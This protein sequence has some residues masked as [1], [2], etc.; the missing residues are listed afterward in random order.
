MRRRD[1]SRWLE[2]VFRDGPLASRISVLEDQAQTEDV[3]DV[4]AS[5]AQAI[6]ARYDTAPAIAAS[7]AP[8]VPA[9]RQN[10]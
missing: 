1:F 6:R 2:T 3:A 7:V 9:E 4:A 5:I 10:A 8:N